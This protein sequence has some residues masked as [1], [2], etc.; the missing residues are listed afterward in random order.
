MKFSAAV[1]VL[2]LADTHAFVMPHTR[3]GVSTST[4]TSLR[5]A[6][7]DS[8]KKGIKFLLVP[9][10]KQTT[11]APAPIPF[12][13]IPDVPVDAPVVAAAAPVVQQQQAPLRAQVVAAT[14]PPAPVVVETPPVVVPEVVTPPPP[15]IVTAS[16]PP[17]VVATPHVNPSTAE[18]V[19]NSFQPIKG[20]QV[21]WTE[22]VDDSY[23]P[24]LQETVNLPS[25][26]LHA[27]AAR[28]SDFNLGAWFQNKMNNGWG[29][30]GPVNAGPPKTLEAV[31]PDAALQLRQWEST[32]GQEFMSS[33]TNFKMSVTDLAALLSS[34]GA[35]SQED[36]E[37]ALN[38]KETSVWY[39]A[40]AGTVGVAWLN[41][42]VGDSSSR[43]AA[44]VAREV[45]A[46]E[47]Q[48]NKLALTNNE[49]AKRETLVADQ[50]TQLT[51]ATTAV[52]KQLAELNAAKAQRDYDVATMKSDLREMRNQLDLAV[53]SEQDLRVS[54]Q[55]TQAQL[56]TETASLRKQL[57]E[58]LAAEAAVQK[59]LKSTKNKMEKE[60]KTIADAKDQAEKE[61]VQAKKQ[62]VTLEKEKQ[63]M[64]KEI[65]ALQAQVQAMQE[66][67][68]GPKTTVTKGSKA[69]EPPVSP[70][71]AKKIAVSDEK[72]TKMPEKVA[73]SNEKETKTVTAK[74]AKTETVVAKKA[75]PKKATAKEPKKAV[76]KKAVAKKA[77]AK[78]AAPKKAVDTEKVVLENLSNAFFANITEPVGSAAEPEGHKVSS[79]TKTIKVKN[80]S[81]TSS[82]TKKEPSPEPTADSET[83]DWSAMSKTSL[84]R[85]KVQELQD[86]LKERVPVRIGAIMFLVF[87]FNFAL[88]HFKGCFILQGAK[89]EENGKALKKAELVEQ[90]LSA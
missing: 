20:M 32:T 69:A 64:E 87:F 44:K 75:E 5:A 71:V 80:A 4:T 38:L 30:A 22:K 39:L 6:T 60:L 46:K 8:L 7:G 67:L 74:K 54:L 37:R 36:F 17:E 10:A 86:Y 21:D 45:A 14:P 19:L 90:I 31:N 35:Y 11:T 1:L 77:V 43:E 48:L 2:A 16:P 63:S 40:V 89:V 18:E 70:P 42:V 59:E 65:A 76:A 57:E 88:S 58:R 15:P 68:E 61:V 66:R 82:A 78:K 47:E 28:L 84:Q 26:D 29:A 51:A 52:T 73:A 12:K 49:I 41:M 3:V 79:D 23:R 55:S 85:K 83:D 24:N 72:E 13:D 9:N 34:G 56:D 33:Y 25:V 27:P 62:V 50:V 81:K 53:S